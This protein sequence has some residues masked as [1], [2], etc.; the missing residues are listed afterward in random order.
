M[1]SQSICRKY[2][3]QIKEL[4]TESDFRVFMTLVRFYSFARIKPTFQM[5]DVR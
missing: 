2:S 4:I 3:G 5:G 1:N